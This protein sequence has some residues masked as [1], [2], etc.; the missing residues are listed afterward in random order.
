[1]LDEDEWAELEPLL[2]SYVENIKQFRL[3]NGS[4]MEAAVRQGFDR[5]ALEYYHRV[6]GS[7]ESNIMTLWH[8]RA[9]D[10][11]PP[12]SECGKPLRTPVAKLCAACGTFREI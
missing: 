7:H 5:P 2:R 8:H 3:K 1:M 11:G 6:T 10:Y 4:A 9:A 12:C